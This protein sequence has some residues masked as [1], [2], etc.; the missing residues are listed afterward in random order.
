MGSGWGK[1]SEKRVQVTPRSQGSETTLKKQK[2]LAAL[3][4]LMVPLK[5]SMV[6]SSYLLANHFLSAR[7]FCLLALEPSVSPKCALLP[8]PTLAG[9]KILTFLVL[10]FLNFLNV[11][12]EIPTSWSSRK[13][14][15]TCQM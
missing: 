14:K 15:K 10:G 7:R 2:K 1:L 12:I 11:R 8:S 4:A 9:W 3:H 5:R 13:D 6:M